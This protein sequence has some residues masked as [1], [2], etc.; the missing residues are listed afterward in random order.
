MSLE[1]CLGVRGTLRRA[2]R[3]RQLVTAS[4]GVLADGW[5]VTNGGAIEAVGTHADVAS[6]LKG[7]D[8]QEVRVLT[9]GFVDAHTHVVYGGHR[10]D[11]F[12]GRCAGE[13]YAERAERGGG[14]AS[15]VRA[16][17]AATTEELRIS[18]QIRLEASRALGTVAWEVKSGYGLDLATELR[19]LEVARSLEAPISTTLLLHGVP[20]GADRDAFL[21]EIE[22]VWLPEVTLRSI[23]D[24]V[25]V[26]VES[27][28]FT[29]EEAR[30]LGHAASG[31]GLR[32][33]LHVDQLEN[34][35]GAALAAEL[36]A[37]TADHLEHTDLAGIAAL[38]A[39]GVIPILVPGSVISL[40]LTHYPNARAMLDADLPVV[41]A[42]DFNPGSSPHLSLPFVMHLA[43]TQMA[44]TFEECLRACTIH[45]ATSLGLKTFGDLKPGKSSKVL[46]WDVDDWREIIVYGSWVRPTLL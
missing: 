21:R 12:A 13:T 28:A 3:A 31:L 7:V 40:G 23:A 8:V 36:G 26:F 16:T 15:T 33:R 9:P 17:R 35:G 27:V 29:V 37:V 32:L 1:L 42:S 41:L 25:D 18:A 11:C 24:Y 4:N 22:E 34:S 30:R 45:A 39:A 20:D 14:I 5:L 19:L 46:A 2:F 38:K 43:H 6:L 44:M 10:A